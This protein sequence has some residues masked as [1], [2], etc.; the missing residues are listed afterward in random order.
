MKRQITLLE[1]GFINPVLYELLLLADPSKEMIDA[2]L[3]GSYVFVAEQDKET[4]GVL[5]LFPLTDKSAEIKNVAV[6]PEL[7][8]RGTGTALI[9]HAIGFAALRQYESICIGTANSSIAQLYLYQKLGFGI[10]EIRR[11]F[12]TRNY[13]DPITENGLRAEHMIILTRNLSVQL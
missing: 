9:E 10:T 8:G 3:P 5:V 6:K 2:Y 7:Q 4:A 11:D 1:P 12:F 13:P